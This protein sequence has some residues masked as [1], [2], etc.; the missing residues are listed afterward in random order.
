MTIS[1]TERA[2][3]RRLIALQALAIRKLGA[4]SG[5]VMLTSSA[6]KAQPVF[7]SSRQAP[8]TNI[9]LAA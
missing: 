1:L 5:V 2:R 8:M 6:R 7:S 9:F 3:N 4:D